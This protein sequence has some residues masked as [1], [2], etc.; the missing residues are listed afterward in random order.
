[1]K[2]IYYEK[3]IPKILLTKLNSRFKILHPLLFTGLNAVK[4]DKKMK[5]PVLPA[6]NWVK[7]RNIQTGVCGT[8]ISF[9]RSTPGTSSALEPIPGS[10]RTYMGHETVGVVEEAGPAVTKFKPGDRVTLREYMSS[11]GNK[12]IEPACRFCEDGNYC[13]CENYGEPS[14]IAPENTGAGFGDY[15]IAPERQLTKIYDG[16][17]DDTATMIEPAAV[18]LHSVLLAPPEK[19]EKVMVLGCGTIGLGIVQSVKL[20]QPDCTV[21]V[22]ERVKEKQELALRLGADKV[23]TGDTYEYIEKELDGKLYHGMMGNKMVLGGFDRIYDCVGGDWANNNC[24]RWLRARGTLVKVGHHMCGTKFDETPI[25]WQELKIIGVDAHG[26]EDF[27]GK[28]ISTF[29]LVQ[30]LVISGRLDLSCFITHR[31]PLSDYKKALKLMLKGDKSV[32]KIVLDCRE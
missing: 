21:Y 15:Y 28:H 14:S 19:G 22:L 3:N 30:E 23:I 10:A 29:D 9:F 7:V 31:F 6:G 8:D 2:S 12:D 18:S 11:C 16:I 20:V 27:E 26:M 24:V 17:D 5:D 4:F 32:I 25:W 1:M 13:L